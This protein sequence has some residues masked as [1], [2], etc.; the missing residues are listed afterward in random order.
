MSARFGPR[1]LAAFIAVAELSSF[2][3]AAVRLHLTP[4]AVSSLIGEFEDTLRF[5][6]F[7]RNTRKVSLT[8]QG[9]RFLPAAIAAQRQFRLAEIAAEDAREGSFEILR[10]AAPQ[11]MASMILPGLI[12]EFSSTNPRVRVRIRD[13]GVV[14]L[15]ELVESGEADLALGPEA[16]S[17]DFVRSR[18]IFSSPWVL[19]C[20]PTH[21]FATSSTLRWQDLRKA[22]L[23]MAGTDHEQSLP[24][25]PKN[26]PGSRSAASMEIVDNITTALGMA[27]AGRYVT[28]S[29]AYVGVLAKP[30][31]LTMRRLGSPSLNRHVSLFSPA[32]RGQS[33]GALAFAEFVF[34]SLSQRFDET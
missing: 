24:P 23:C 3:R 16:P 19:W 6:L 15:T 20:A 25:L 32:K 10:V 17:N 27:A 11:V 5:Q 22:S 31:G 9:R 33:S 21:A 14:W 34:A 1:Q 8:S 30:M 2:T 29:P 7:S 12:E 28:M 4:S 26:A 13:S 18:R